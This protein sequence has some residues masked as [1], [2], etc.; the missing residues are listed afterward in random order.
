MVKCESKKKQ[1]SRR[2]CL[3]FCRNIYDELKKMYLKYIKRI[4]IKC[5]SLMKVH[6]VLA[7]KMFG[8]HDFP[9]SKGVIIFL[10]VSR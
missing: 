4:N 6:K 10:C 7:T 9:Y 5:S 8:R 1:T 2:H 3:C